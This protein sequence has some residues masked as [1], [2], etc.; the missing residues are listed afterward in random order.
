MKPLHLRILLSL[1]LAVAAY[2]F[3]SSAYPFHLHFQE[4][5][6][7]FE[8]T[9][10]YAAHTLWW[11]GG[12]ANY[13]SR[14]IV[15]FFYLSA[16]GP[17][18]MAL[19]ILGFQLS[20]W[21]TFRQKAIAA[22]PLSFIP[23]IVFM[24]Y[25]C[26]ENGLLTVLIALTLSQLSALAIMRIHKR[27][28]RVATSLVAMPLLLFLL[29]S[30]AVACP[31]IVLL[32]EIHKK[33]DWK[34]GL[35]FLAAIAVVFFAYVWIA[36][37]VFTVSRHYIMR[38][39]SYHRHFYYTSTFAWMCAVAVVV[40]PILACILPA[41]WSASRKSGKPK[42]AAVS[43]LAI[44][45]GA[46]AWALVHHSADYTKEDIMAYDYLA[47]KKQWDMILDR[48]ERRMPD[49]PY[50]VAGLNL[51]LAMT[52]QM[53]DRLFDYFQ[54]GVEGLR[55]SFKLVALSGLN[56]VELL[57]NLGFTNDDQYLAF[58]INQSIPDN[59]MSSRM[60]QRLA[61]TNIVKGNYDIARKYLQTLQNTIY[62]RKWA[63]ENLAL[64]DLADE[65]A[66]NSYSVYGKRREV[67]I[68]NDYFHSNYFDEMLKKNLADNPTHKM[69]Y[70]YLMAYYLLNLDFDN[71]YNFF[72]M[73]NFGDRIP[74]SYQEALCLMWVQKHTTWDGMPWPVGADTKRRMEAFMRDYRNNIGKEAL[75]E[76]HGN[77]F[78]SYAIF[79]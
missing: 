3:Y 38:G 34:L 1:L 66:I 17:L 7:T 39:T 56:T 77:N 10:S 58:E 35:A 57:W 64:L 67:N 42:Y 49:N 23:A 22:Y 32:H 24:G 44:A 53:P 12:L 41:S 69:A 2:L 71:F 73:I 30:M 9:A 52:G 27:E 72:S 74:R 21:L 5:M 55:P 13:L 50:S 36:G 76:R 15:Q 31:L 8:F 59:Q 46:G 19:L 11:P 51:A 20:T 65:E 26:N 70:D 18:L 28:W 40:A 25:F 63:N 16:A 48:A 4:E 54:N 68:K 45:V 14:F 75:I 29:G 47:Y 62:Y 79:R 6:Q 37:S 43:I 60:L 61:E 78:W 33:Q